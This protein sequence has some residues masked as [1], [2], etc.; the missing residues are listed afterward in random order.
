[1]RGSIEL[2]HAWFRDDC[3][4][5]REWS[6]EFSDLLILEAGSPFPASFQSFGKWVAPDSQLA[7][8][9]VVRFWKLG[10]VFGGNYTA[11]EDHL[12][13][14]WALRVCSLVIL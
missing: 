1:M 5:T 9:V 13:L 4:L 10:T 11:K 2:R 7:F 8:D 12:V 14:G 6:N 3:C